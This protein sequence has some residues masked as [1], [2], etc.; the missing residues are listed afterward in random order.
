MDREVQPD[1][2]LAEGA[3]VA[4]VALLGLIVRIWPALMNDFPLHDGGM[5]AAMVGDIRAAHAIPLV[6]SYNGIQI[7]FAYPPLALLL[8]AVAPFD[9]LT[10][11]RFAPAIVASLTV[12]VIYLI[13]REVTGSHMRSLLAVLFFALTPA[14]FQWLVI[15]GGLTRA[16]GFLFAAL[17]IWQLFRLQRTRSW[18]EAIAA[19]AFFGLTVL[20]HPEATLFAGVTSLLILVTVRSR[21]LLIRTLGG[22]VVGGAVASPWAA[23]VLSRYGPQ[24]LVSALGTGSDVAAMIARLLQ[25]WGTGEILM[26]VALMLGLLGIAVALADR[27][28]FLPAWVFVLLVTDSRGALMFVMVPLM[29]LAAVGFVDGLCG[30]VMRLPVAELDRDDGRAL[31]ARGPRIA[32]AL[33]LVPLLMSSFAAGIIPPENPL[34]LKSRTAMSWI[35]TNTPPGARF[36][37]VSG[38]AWYDDTTAE[39]FPVLA[40]RQSVATPQ[41]FEWLGS[42]RWTTQQDAYTSLQECSDPKCIAAWMDARDVTWLLVD[43]SQK[44][45]GLRAAVL[46]S[47][48]FDARLVLDTAVVAERR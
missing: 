2:G 16:P 27:R 30:R 41:G 4:T 37:V 14:G 43:N 1:R 13:A 45:A 42:A 35:E 32:F 7:P 9:P 10:I 8:A 21:P 3:A 5:F 46:L 23:L 6:T 34:P 18:R 47:P 28:F 17:G 19:G 31:A 48:A 44:D 24:P 39:W 11:E 29:I 38:E 40:Q 33:L 20:T 12:P 22:G 25:T 26:P 36:A 15:G